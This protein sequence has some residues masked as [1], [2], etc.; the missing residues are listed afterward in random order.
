MIPVD[1]GL[2]G[3]G[4]VGAVVLLVRDAVA[5][6]VRV[7]RLDADGAARLPD[8]DGARCGGQQRPV[9]ARRGVHIARGL[10]ARIRVR[11]GGQD[12]EVVSLRGLDVGPHVARVV[13]RE[14]AGAAPRDGVGHGAVR[15]REHKPVRA[16][17][18]IGGQR[19][20]HVGDRGLPE[21]HEPQRAPLD[22]RQA[23]VGH[24]EI[25]EDILPE[26]IVPAVVAVVMRERVAAQIQPGGRDELDELGVVRAGVVGLRLVDERALR[27]HE[28]R[29]DVRLGRRQQGALGVGPVEVDAHGVFQRAGVARRQGDR[30]AFPL[31]ALQQGHR[32][33][34]PGL[35]GPPVEGRGGEVGGEQVPVKGRADAEGLVEAR[36]GRLERQGVHEN[37]RLVAGRVG[38]GRGLGLQRPLIR[39]P[40]RKRVAGAQAARRGPP[41]I[42]PRHAEIVLGH[43]LARHAVRVQHAARRVEQRYGVVAVE[44]QDLRARLPR[45]RAVRGRKRR[46]IRRHHE[47]RA[48]GD[49]AGQVHGP[50]VAPVAMDDQP[51]PR[52]GKG[53]HAGIVQLDVVCARVGGADHLADEDDRV[54][55]G[56]QV[57]QVDVGVDR[58]VIGRGGAGLRGRRRAELDQAALPVVLDR[59]VNLAR[60]GAVGARRDFAAEVDV[61]VAAGIDRREVRVR[62]D[63]ILLE[64]LE[65]GELDPGEGVGRMPPVRHRERDVGAGQVARRQPAGQGV[66]LDPLV[67]PDVG[68]EVAHDH[69]LG[70][71]GIGLPRG[72]DMLDRPPHLDRA[73][74]VLH[75]A[76]GGLVVDAVQGQRVQRARDLDD[77]LQGPPIDLRR[78]RRLAHLLGG[79]DGVPAEEPVVL[80]GVE[81][82]AVAHRVVRVPQRRRHGHP[83]VEI[84]VVQ[85]LEGDDV[86]VD[87]L[88]GRNHGGI[89]R[90]ARRA[91]AV[92]DVPRG[93]AHPD[94][95]GRET[96]QRQHQTNRARQLFRVHGGSSM[97]PLVARGGVFFP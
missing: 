86:G 67:F 32:D 39:P 72:G 71:E 52:Q 3:I 56:Q 80:A 25:G 75:H 24:D 35:P 19:Q 33:L 91:H 78:A 57:D 88:Q 10:E 83:V 22:V 44:L 50:R 31:L 36:H 68:V 1:V 70:L 2:D 55:A 26:I 47:S 14:V 58:Q 43:R 30:R 12:M 74:E 63:G 20:V 11:V 37:A 85:L 49:R 81:G 48:R 84:A 16:V 40:L 53:G 93:H 41:G 66:D 21:H 54:V 62:Q 27:A 29:E 79:Q 42:G 38:A 82:S 5:V 94:R 95:P 60:G 9:R 4:R 89:I 97:P 15:R 7:G 23:V 34:R 77:G 59:V 45:R 64:R 90:L 61:V 69:V 8:V 17:L 76:G 51:V 6:P 73:H 46:S 28:R 18:E 87:A 92:L 13:D 96:R 65:L